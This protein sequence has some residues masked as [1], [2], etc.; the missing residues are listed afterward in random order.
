MVCHDGGGGWS[1]EGRHE[2][3]KLSAVI[4][5]KKARRIGLVI[6]AKFLNKAVQKKLRSQIWEWS[7]CPK[8]QVLNWK[9]NREDFH[10]L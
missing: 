3:A 8:G 5:P 4:S 10:E 9:T 6:V 7:I 2:L 1:S